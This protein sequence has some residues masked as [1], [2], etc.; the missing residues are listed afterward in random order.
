M[1]TD[2]KSGNNGKLEVKYPRVYKD[3]RSRIEKGIL[4]GALPGVKQLAL[5]YDVNFM[6]VDKA[7]KKLEADGF[8]YRI[9]RKGTYV[10]RQY[11]VAICFNGPD[12]DIMTVPVYY[13]AMMGAQKYFSENNCPMFL[14]GS[15]LNRRN[16]VNVLRKKVDGFLFIYNSNYDFPEDMLRMPCVR[17][18]GAP[19]DLP[20]YDHIGYENAKVGKL[21]TEYLV[22][23]GCRSGAYIG[24]NS[25]NLFKERY[26]T[27][28][29][30]MTASGCVAYEF[31][32]DGRERYENTEEQVN[33]LL[34]M[35]TLPDGIF[36]PSDALMVGVCITLY[37]HG[38]MPGK[39]IQVV[40]CN[41]TGQVI[42]N[43]PDLFASIDIRSDD[44]GKLASELLLKKIKNP[45]RPVEVKLLE[46]RLILPGEVHK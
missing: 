2:L 35:K 3:I 28:M 27:F 9:P 4:T 45:A 11:N 40:A 10:K 37:R 30:S 6:T 34:A 26:M 24:P 18:M 16:V 5:E 36:C 46:P 22:S 21:A 38:I 23:K 31:I 44:I 20:E 14:E 29:D 13:R 19:G 12:P 7:I 17:I 15:L 32:C 42:R 8:V 25:Q 33:K 1:T 43:V 41:S 39:D